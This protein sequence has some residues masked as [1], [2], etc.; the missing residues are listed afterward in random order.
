MGKLRFPKPEIQ[1][2]TGHGE[3]NGLPFAVPER[4]TEKKTKNGKKGRLL[5]GHL[6]GSFWPG[7]W[8]AEA[9]KPCP[10]AGIP[11]AKLG[12]GT[13]TFDCLLGFLATS[14][15]RDVE[16]PFD[17]GLFFLVETIMSAPIKET[18]TMASRFGV[19]TGHSWSWGFNND[20]CVAY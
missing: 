14:F 19:L 20:A 6:C 15:E 11:R 3:T 5:S 7:T 17:L 4:K 9:T 18:M 12:E 13:R 1:T 16:A 8:P 2:P 10:H